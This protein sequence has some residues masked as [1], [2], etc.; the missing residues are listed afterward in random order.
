MG[1]HLEQIK[2]QIRSRVP[3]FRRFVHLQCSLA[4][5][6]CVRWVN[7]RLRIL[8]PPMT[9]RITTPASRAYCRNTTTDYLNVYTIWSYLGQKKSKQAQFTC[10]IQ[11][12]NIATDFF[13]GAFRKRHYFV[14]SHRQYSKTWH[15][16]EGRTMHPAYPIVVQSKLHLQQF[17]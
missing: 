4:S 3:R 17:S 10:D 13:D 5:N 8:V 14:V 1:K 6:V 7:N 15:V 9:F 12:S 2:A 16:I 11:N